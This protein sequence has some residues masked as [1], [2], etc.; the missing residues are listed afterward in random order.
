MPR[1]KNPIIYKTTN[2]INGKIYVGQDSYND[3]DYYGSGTIIKL[4]I[5]KHGK[6]NFKKE[7]LEHCSLENLNDR[8]CYWI[9][10]LQSQNKDVGYNICNGGGFG[11]T[12]TQHPERQKIL[13]RMSDGLKAHYNENPDAKEKLA[14]RCRTMNVGKESPHKGKSR[15]ELKGIRKF[16]DDSLITKIIQMY[17]TTGVVKITKMLQSEGHS[18]GRSTVI[19]TLKTAGVYREG[20]RGPFGENVLSKDSNGRF[21]SKS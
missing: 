2:L 17:E 9:R 6:E 15:P 21:T 13:K 7:I 1:K 4:A 3:S 12:I 5:N 11:D 16:A 10:K 8:E 18:I 20:K 19:N 14:D